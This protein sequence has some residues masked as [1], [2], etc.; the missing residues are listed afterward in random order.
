MSLSPSRLVLAP[1]EATINR[2]LDYDPGSRAA[3]AELAGTTLAIECTVPGIAAVASFDRTGRLSLA[4]V[5]EA[6]PDVRLRG[7]PPALAVLLSRAGE[8]YSFADTGVAVEGDQDILIRLGAVLKTLEIDW[9]QA[10]A[11]LERDWALPLTRALARGD[12]AEVIGDVPAHLAAQA[13]RHANRW[14]AEAAKRSSSGLGEYVREETGLTVS[15]SEAR[16]WYQ[17][18]RRLWAD[19]ER[20]GARLERLER[21]LEP[22]EDE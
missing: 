2:A 10:L 4:A 5:P 12:L 6:S 8:T 14:L 7:S 15:N 3:L 22:G 9:E 13:A 18:V 19:T 16:G 11:D 20:L 1:L 21:Q 17:D